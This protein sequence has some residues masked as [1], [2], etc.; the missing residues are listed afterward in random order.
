MA[1]TAQSTTD[2]VGGRDG[3][4]PI[5][6]E[7]LN[8]AF[9]AVVDQMGVMLEKVSFS[10]VT[11]IGKDYNCA[12][13]TARGEVFSR[14]K[15]GVPLIGGTVPHRIKAILEHIPAGQIRDGD[16]IV[17]NDPFLG[18]THGQDVSAVMPVFW[19]GELIAFVHAASHWPDTGGAVPGS[20]NSEAT[21]THGE[22]LLIPPIHLIR[23]GEWD[24][25][26]E[27]LILRNVR[28]PRIIRGDLRG[29]VEAARTG[30]QQ[31]LDLVAKYG[32]D[33]IKA[34]MEAVMD[35]SE[36]LLREEW[37]KIPD[38]TYSWTDFIDAD[39]GATSDDPVKVGLDLRISGN[40]A[41]F[42][43]SRTAEQAR[44]PI[45]A[46]LSTTYSACLTA[47]R[48]VFPHVPGNDGIYRAIDIV[49]PLGRVINAEYPRPVSGNAANSAEK[50]ISCVHGAFVQAVPERGMASSTN[51]VNIS[52]H[53]HDVRPGRGEEYVMYIWGAGGWGARPGRKDNYSSQMP[54]A[55]GSI[56]Q[57]AEML[58]REYPIRFDG[59]RLKPDSEGAG[60]HRGGFAI[61]F[62][63]R[64]TDGEAS[65]NVLGDRD[66]VPAWGVEGGGIPMGNKLIYGTGTD[67]E[68]DLGMMEAGFPVRAGVGLSFWQGGGG[69]WRAAHERP[70][71]WVVEDVRAGLVTIG[72]AR[73]VYGVEVR[74]SDRLTA[75][76]EVDEAETARLRAELAAKAS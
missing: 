29:M 50:I 64:V 5:T 42:D 17:H 55:P 23:E 61:E 65:I 69:G 48:N 76:Y 33:L 8:N 19:D 36:T 41:F 35:W 24:L 62:P 32:V 28:I 14:G 56:L 74:E 43:F 53:G 13:A 20:F 52:I 27:R 46:T 73:D 11:T 71:D 10:M 25:A 72:R 67:E 60:Y 21:S 63:F 75:S 70:V 51:L 18:G 66:K 47:I 15:G 49:V 9:S 34:E 30:K 4:D 59:W 37:A 38:A 12:L 57:P 1:A 31:V 44:G 3:I 16:V 26:V 68:R 22:T 58:E 45:N 40:S 39:P 54:Q 7:V 2:A 6:F